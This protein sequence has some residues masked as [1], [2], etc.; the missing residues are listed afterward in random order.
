MILTL[1]VA[2]V[3]MAVEAAGMLAATAFSAAATADGKSY[4]TA[5]GVALTLIAFGA[6]AAIAG[7]ALAVGKAKPWSRTPAVMIQLLGVVGG[8]MMLD[9]HRLDWGV[10]TLI[11]VAVTL[12]ALFAPASIRALN[13]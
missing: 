2:V 1:R 7:F 11:L 6:A 3:A 9:G 10:P 4:Q 13:R 8:V 5:S 12:G